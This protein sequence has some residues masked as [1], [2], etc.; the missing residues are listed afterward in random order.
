MVDI[1]SHG[2][3]CGTEACTSPVR[4][5]RRSLLRRWLMAGLVICL[6]A[7]LLAGG[8]VAA[9]WVYAHP[10]CD[11]QRGI[12][13]GERRGEPLTLDVVTPPSPN[14]LGIVF[15]VSGGW[16]SSPNSFRAWLLAPLLRH[17]YTLFAVAHVPQPRATVDEIVA[18][19]SRGVR[20]VRAHAAE[21]HVDP[22]RI[23]VT[24]G[25]SGGHLALMLATRGGPGETGSADPLAD[26]SSAVQAA[27]VFCPVTDLTN[28]TGST[29]DPGDGG[30][31]PSFRKAFDQEPIDMVRWRETSREL[32]PIFHVTSELPPI[33]IHH[34]DRDTLVPLD[35]SIRFCDRAKTLGC[36]VTL[37]VIE[38]AGHGWLTMPWHIMRCAAWFDSRLGKP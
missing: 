31:P 32:S 10:P 33:L 4:P 27:A 2:V 5:Q 30:P 9:A 17:G 16:K 37:T 12:V 21:F 36:D 6:A 34:G 14:G 13:Y 19:I 24:G 20:Y 22:D 8:L 25:S 38:G 15:L 23:G 7:A 11:W 1:A 29:E 3:E 18:D 35:Q 26:V 28:L